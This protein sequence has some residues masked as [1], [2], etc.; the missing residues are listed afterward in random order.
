MAQVRPTASFS[1]GLGLGFA[2]SAVPRSGRAKGSGKW[3]A[4]QDFPASSA[5]RACMG[6]GSKPEKACAVPTL[7]ALAGSRSFSSGF[8]GS[9]VAMFLRSLPK[10]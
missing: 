8:V 7:D 4:L 1:L 9:V 3:Q 10:P 6:N 5:S 2:I